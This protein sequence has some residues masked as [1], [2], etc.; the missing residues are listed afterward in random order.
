MNQI[1]SIGHNS[2]PTPFDEIETRINELYDE[3]KLWL[4]GEPVTKQEQADALNTLANHIRDAAKQADQMR[5]E[6]AKPFDDGK[7]EVQDRYNPLIQKGK[8]KTELALNA[9]KSALKPYLL[10]L[11]RIQQEAAQKAREEAERAERD[12]QAAMQHR[13]PSNIEQNEEAHRLAEQAKAAQQA[14]NKASNAK[15]HAK[16]A[17]RATGL[18]TRTKVSIVNE[19]DAAAWA[20]KHDREALMIFV[21]TQAEKAVRA[22]ATKLEGFNITEEKV[23]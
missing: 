1:A 21:L 22:G 16:G 11:D 10:E 6:E 15:A 23:I 9:V 20:W 7:K 8:G 17:G 14:A 2:P 19:R 13:D 3:A 12:A 5:K 18:R 4:D